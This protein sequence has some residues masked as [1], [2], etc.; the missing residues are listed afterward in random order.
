MIYGDRLQIVRELRGL[1]TASVAEALSVDVSVVEAWETEQMSMGEATLKRFSLL[2]NFPTA[3]F[4]QPAP[5][6]MGEGSLAWH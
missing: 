5:P 2:T 6:P 4:R 3:F 1:T